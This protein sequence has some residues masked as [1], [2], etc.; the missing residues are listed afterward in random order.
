[1]RALG[2]GGLL[3]QDPEPMRPWSDPGDL[4]AGPI[5]FTLSFFTIPILLLYRKIHGEGKE[6]N[7]RHTAKHQCMMRKGS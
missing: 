1:M 2:G 7:I 4:E 5:A 6:T 3:S